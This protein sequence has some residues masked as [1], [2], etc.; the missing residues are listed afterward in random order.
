MQMI[1]KLTGTSTSFSMADY[2]M[3][4]NVSVSR[5]G[6]ARELGTSAGTDLILPLSVSISMN[7]TIFVCNINDL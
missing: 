4:V 2:G 3:T 1:E 7:D 5:N 6:G